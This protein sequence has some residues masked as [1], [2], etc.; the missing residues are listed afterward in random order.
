MT[1]PLI[2][3][4]PEPGGAAT[5]AAA[6]A[7]GLEAHGFPLFAIA[8]VVWEAPSGID[9]LLLGSANALRHAG[10]GLAAYAGLPAYAVGE[11]TAA[12]AR[13]AG[14]DVVATGRGG[15]QAVLPQVRHRHLLRL[16]GAERVALIPPPGVTIAERVVYAAAP[17]AMPGALALLL[18]ARALPG[19][20]VALHS[21]AAARHFTAEAA[22][23][24]LDRQR[25]ALAAL[26]P[27]IAAAAGDGW[28]AVRWAVRA[29][30]AALLA[31]AG[32][33][34]QDSAR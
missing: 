9:A 23:I 22:R 27:R 10:P 13:A 29:D 28:R 15:L 4:R 7:L 6:R 5:V 14:L 32:E 34:C 2:V 31:L 11:A 30:D 19:A 21:A 25:I 20:V 18:S 3:I 33:M 8:P 12:A 1:L 24:G 16:A 26:G 17:V